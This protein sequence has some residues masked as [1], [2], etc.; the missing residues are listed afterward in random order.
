MSMSASQSAAFKAASGFTPQATTTLFVGALVA[1]AML[2][3]AW[4][5]YSIWRGWATKNL[6]RSIAGSSAIR[7]IL[8]LMILT[9]L[10]LS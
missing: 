6:D 5:A 9:V 10:V 4:A 2:W 3:G 1:L 7:L 8:L